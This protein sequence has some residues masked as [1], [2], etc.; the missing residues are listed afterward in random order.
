MGLCISIEPRAAL[1]RYGFCCVLAVLQL[2]E[3]KGVRHARWSSRPLLRAAAGRQVV[4]RPF[5]VYQPSM[6]IYISYPTRFMCIYRQPLLSSSYTIAPFV[7]TTVRLSC[8]TSTIHDG[9][10]FHSELVYK[11]VCLIMTLRLFCRDLVRLC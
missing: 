3:G 2:Y 8:S 9:G 1:Y 4:P 7:D 5:T 11:S 6:Y 10:L